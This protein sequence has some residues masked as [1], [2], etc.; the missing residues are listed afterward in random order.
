MQRGRTRQRLFARRIEQALFE[1]AFFQ[2][3][4]GELQRAE[5]DRLDVLT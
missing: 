5:A 2:L 4:E 3:L 1:Q